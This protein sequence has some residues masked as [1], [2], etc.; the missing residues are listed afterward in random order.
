MIIIAG[1]LDVD[2]EDRDAYLAAVD[3]VARL[4]RASAGCLDFVQAAD[5]IDAGR[6][7]VYERWE[8]DED[9]HRFRGSGGP[10]P[11]L[12]PLRSADVQKYRICGVEAP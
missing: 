9:L 10:L 4:A 3:G 6:I 2:A 8:S 11:D 5:P 12:P 1:R 7:N